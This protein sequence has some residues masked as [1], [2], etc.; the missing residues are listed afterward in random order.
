MVR[1]K[2]QQVYEGHVQNGKTLQLIAINAHTDH[3]HGIDSMDVDEG[4]L[5]LWR[6]G[7]SLFEG[8]VTSLFWGWRGIDFCAGRW[9]LFVLICLYWGHLDIISYLVDDGDVCVRNFERNPTNQHPK[10]SLATNKENNKFAL[11]SQHLP[12]HASR[13]IPAEQWSSMSILKKI[14]LKHPHNIQEKQCVRQNR[15]SQ[16]FSSSETKNNFLCCFFHIHTWKK[17]LHDFLK[18]LSLADFTTR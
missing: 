14:A 8:K 2:F 17:H 18:C 5:L 12:F 6:G 7:G 4:Q 1:Q 15:S 11:W 10:Y 3:R 9:H 16:C 13:I